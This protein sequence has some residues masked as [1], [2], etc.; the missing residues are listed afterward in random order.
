[1][2]VTVNKPCHVP[3]ASR[4]T[5]WE[6]GFTKILFGVSEEWV[7]FWLHASLVTDLIKLKKH[8]GEREREVKKERQLHSFLRYTQTQLMSEAYLEPSS[9][10]TMQLFFCEMLTFIDRYLFSQKNY[11]ANVRLSSKYPCCR[12]NWIYMEC[13]FTVNIFERSCFGSCLV[14]LFWRLYRLCRESCLYQRL[15]EKRHVPALPFLRLWVG[16]SLLHW[17]CSIV[18]Y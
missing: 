12:V 13:R 5:T 14:V 7:R 8:W 18:L 16:A 17:D 4:I 9:T 3:H 1:M 15:L 10:S 11:I 2:L 6:T